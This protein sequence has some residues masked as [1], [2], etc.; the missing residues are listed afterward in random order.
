MLLDPGVLVAAI[1]GCEK[2]EQVGQDHYKGLISAK[3]GSIQSE[4]QTTFKI[5]DKDPPNRYT[6]NVEGQGQAGFVNATV[7]IALQPAEGGEATQMRYDADAN[8]GGRIAQVGQRMVRATATAMIDRGFDDLR[9][10]MEQEQA[11]EAGASEAAI[12]RAERSQSAWTKLRRLLRTAFTFLRALLSPA[13]K[14]EPSAS[15]DHPASGSASPEPSSSG[16]PSKSARSSGGAGSGLP[17]GNPAS[18]RSASKG[19]ASDGSPSGRS[20][21]GGSSGGESG[22][23]GLPSSG[24]KGPPPESE[25]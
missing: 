23:P 3:I 16:A 7:E 8:V 22:P 15:A 5:T 12:A 25:E 17:S 13:P 18:G 19:A 4:Y 2:L 1:P 14:H 24:S 10:K 9:V 20:S 11:S 21:G 6:L